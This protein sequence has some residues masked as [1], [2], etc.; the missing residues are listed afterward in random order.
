MTPLFQVALSFLSKGWKPWK[1]L[2]YNRIFRNWKHIAKLF[3]KSSII[4][5]LLCE[6]GWWKVFSHLLLCLPLSPFFFLSCVSTWLLFSLLFWK[7][8]NCACGIRKAAWPLNIGE[9]D[10]PLNEWT[11]QMLNFEILGKFRMLYSDMNEKHSFYLDSSENTCWDLKSKIFNYK[12]FEFNS[13]V[14]FNTF[15]GPIHLKM[16]WNSLGTFFTLELTYMQ[17]LRE[18]SVPLWQENLSIIA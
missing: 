3:L 4:Q 10:R 14:G 5:T 13:P 17:L 15:Q 2:H 12:D 8:Y 1:K 7:Q 11:T 18:L 9:A 16:C 6:C